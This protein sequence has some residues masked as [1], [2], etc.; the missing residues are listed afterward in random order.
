MRKRALQNMENLDISTRRLPRL[1][2]HDVVQIQNQVGS[3]PT[4]WNATD[5]IVEVKSHDQY[6]V[7]IHDSGRLTLRNRK[8]LKKIQLYGDPVNPRDA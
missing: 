7:K 2:F 1:D 5:V 8:F 4:K 6:L 3:K